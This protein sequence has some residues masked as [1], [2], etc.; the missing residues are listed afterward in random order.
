MNLNLSS[1]R[2][3]RIV[4]A[5]GSGTAARL[6]T[7]GLTLL[8]LP[9]AVRYLGAERYGVWA[10]IT[11][12]AVWINLLDLG[13]ANTLTNNI[14]RAYALADKIAAARYF[15]NALVLTCGM[16]A[17]VGWVLP[18]AFPR[19]DWVR[20]FNVGPGVSAAEVEHTV[21]IAL[22]LM[23]LSLPCA[24]VSKLLAGYQELHRNNYATCAG[25]VASL[26]GLVLG[27]A[28]HVSMPA[29]FVMSA[30]CLTFASLAT[31]VLVVGWQK[32]W[33][34]P[35]MSLVDRS[36]LR[37]LLHSGWPFFLIQ[38]AAVVVF[39]SDNLVV[40]HYLGASAVTPYSV[41]WRV[42]GLAAVLQSLIFPALWP[43]YAEAYAKRDYGWIRRTFLMTLKATMALNLSCV[44]LLMLFGRSLIRIWASSAAVPS[45]H[46]LLAM[47]VWAIV[48]G[49]MSVESC[50]LAALNRIREQAVLSILAA[51]LNIA[52]SLLLVHRIGALG[53]IGGTILSYVIVLVI[54]QTL[55]VRNVWRRE[56]VAEGKA[57]LA[58]RSSPFTS[59]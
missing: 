14:S 7:A 33:L 21:A 53:V 30:G 3:G 54:P 56:L 37:E 15:T 47:G 34:L 1:S 28:L 8:S 55:I 23:L 20:L 59:R 57:M 10:T 12:T 38:I 11:T 16:A 4:Q 31:M 49:F 22:G 44:T 17:G 45:L 41:T 18:F 42:V 25:A 9:L 19:I 48:S 32:P 50:L 35:R 13:I 29:L 40:S 36:S 58:F 2:Y 51:A 52:L 26:G 24:L 5:V 43:A 27:I 6:L 39:S 46:L